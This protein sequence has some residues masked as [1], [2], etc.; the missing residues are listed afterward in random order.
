M[1][2]PTKEFI[3]VVNASLG[4]GAKW[5][6]I[7]EF[8]GSAVGIISITN[9]WYYQVPQSLLIAFAVPGVISSVPVYTILNLLLGKTEVFNKARMVYSTNGTFS[10]KCYLEVY[11]HISTETAYIVEMQNHRNATAL[12]ELGSI[13]E[14]W[15]T[16][17]F[18][19]TAVGG[20]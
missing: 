10:T 11:Q 14:G 2:L 3:E 7:A 6:R 1:S 17:E 8:S 16:K 15:S 19:F 4:E 5:I 20:G 18:T 12:C 9:S 13:P